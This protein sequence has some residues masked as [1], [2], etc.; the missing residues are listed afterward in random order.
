MKTTY[1]GTITLLQ[2]DAKTGAKSIYHNDNG[3]CEFYNFNVK[4]ELTETNCHI[5][6]YYQNDPFELKLVNQS[7]GHYKGNL[8]VYR[9]Y[10]ESRGNASLELLQGE[11]KVILIGEYSEE[12]NGFYNCIVEI[13]LS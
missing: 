6:F 9:E 7:D 10:E 12:E 11:K 5:E 3:K 1:K 13:P 4:V 8:Y 2:S